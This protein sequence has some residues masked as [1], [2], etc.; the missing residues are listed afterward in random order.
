M[1]AV[2]HNLNPS[3]VTCRKHR[4]LRRRS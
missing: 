4:R 2:R 3:R 1:V